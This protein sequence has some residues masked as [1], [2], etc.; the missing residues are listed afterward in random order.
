MNSLPFLTDHIMRKYNKIK[1]SKKNL[2]QNDLIKPGSESVRH[3][4]EE[5]AL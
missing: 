3:N 4:R 1:E 2:A 5:M